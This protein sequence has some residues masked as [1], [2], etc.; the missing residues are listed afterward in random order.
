MKCKHIWED[1]TPN[2]YSECLMCP[3]GKMLEPIEHFGILTPNEI[4][5]ME[6]LADDTSPIH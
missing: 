2:G 5:R 4:R 6:G 1:T 3:V